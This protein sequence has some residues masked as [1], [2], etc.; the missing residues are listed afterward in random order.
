MLT[1]PRS[2]SFGR[3]NVETGAELGEDRGGQ[4][5]G[6]DVGE[7]RG[8]WNMENTN[9]TDGNPF[10]HEVK[11]NFHML[12][13]LVLNRIG[14]HVELSCVEEHEAHLTTDGS[15][16]PQQLHWRRRD[17]QPRHWNERQWAGVWRTKK[18]DCLPRKLHILK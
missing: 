17:T 18:P 10:P 2:R 11:I 5:L 15:K 13:A 6:E 3:P 4:P 9:V 8:R 7:L 16:W 14:G 12:G 1:R